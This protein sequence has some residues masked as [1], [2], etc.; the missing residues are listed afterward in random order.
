MHWNVFHFGANLA[1]SPVEGTLVYRR[2]VYALR[3]GSALWGRAVLKW[4]TDCPSFFAVFNC[5][6]EQC[7]LR[8]SVEVQKLDFSVLHRSAADKHVLKRFPP[9][10][11]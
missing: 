2:Q 5:I 6:F 8:C 9:H 3:G 7:V 10:F 4:A 11:A 1:F